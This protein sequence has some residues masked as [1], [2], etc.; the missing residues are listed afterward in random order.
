MVTIVS[1]G[2]VR[3]SNYELVVW[4]LV[5]VALIGDS[6]HSLLQLLL[7]EQFELRTLIDLVGWVIISFLPVAKCS[8]LNVK[9]DSIVPSRDGLDIPVHVLCLLNCF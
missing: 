9:L 1:K 4:C 6:L 5:L 3:D 2:D 7:E 8:F